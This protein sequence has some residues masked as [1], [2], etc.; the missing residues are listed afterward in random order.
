MARKKKKSTATPQAQPSSSS[1]SQSQ[2]TTTTIPDEQ[3]IVELQQ[4]INALASTAMAMPSVTDENVLAQLLVRMNELEIANSVKKKR[5]PKSDHKFW[6]T[7]PVP[8][9][10]N[11]STYLI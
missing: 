8:K 9:H 5:E 11:I 6:N 2:A 7:Q 10:G 3:N 4:R 1:Q